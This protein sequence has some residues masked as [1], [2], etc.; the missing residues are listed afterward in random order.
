MEVFI[1]S[2][3]VIIVLED[4]RFI[5]MHLADTDSHTEGCDAAIDYI[6]YNRYFEELDG[7]QMDYSS[8]EKGYQCV[9]DAVRDVLGFALSVSLTNLPKYY[10]V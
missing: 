7:G 8:G 5:S 3:T 4:G 10:C 1:I 6:L 9:K 2:E